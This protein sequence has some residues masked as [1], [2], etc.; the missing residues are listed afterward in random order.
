MKES[1]INKYFKNFLDWGYKIPDPPQIAV[2]IS[3]KRPFDG[4]GVY[5]KRAIY[6]EGKYLSELKS[7]N[8]KH[9]QP[10]QQQA[11]EE[12]ALIENAL[13][14]IVLGVYVKRGETRIYLFNWK[15]SILYIRMKECI[16]QLA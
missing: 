1:D 3:S 13:I 8:L 7:F 12:V 4:F 11:L 5:N 2:K 14:L 9:I 15:M 6:W 10:H 16:I